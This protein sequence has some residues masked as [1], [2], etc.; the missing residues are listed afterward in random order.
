[1]PGGTVVAIDDYTIMDA[2]PGK[3]DLMVDDEDDHHSVFAKVSSRK[4]SNFSNRRR[5]VRELIMKVKK[6]NR[7]QIGE[8]KTAAVKHSTRSTD[9]GSAHSPL[10]N[11]AS[12]RSRTRPQTRI[13]T[14][15]WRAFLD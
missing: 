1:M 6:I 10:G 5:S 12:T 14:R 3:F 4:A 9:T 13:G 7:M 11:L 8:T 2:P 15:L